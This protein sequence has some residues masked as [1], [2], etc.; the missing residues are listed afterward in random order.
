MRQMRRSMDCLGTPLNG[1]DNA[2][3]PLERNMVQVRLENLCPPAGLDELGP[4]ELQPF[5]APPRMRS[6]LEEQ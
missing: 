6:A 5:R 4:I 2:S 1:S 3:M